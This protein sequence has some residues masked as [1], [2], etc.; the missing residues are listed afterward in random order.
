M[1]GTD[2]DR[3]APIL[4]EAISAGKINLTAIINTHQYARATTHVSNGCL[5]QVIA[6][7]T[8]LAATRS[9]Y[10]A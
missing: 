5:I 8:I 7:G 6:T 4:K 3:V 2:R 1:M 9:W 10:V